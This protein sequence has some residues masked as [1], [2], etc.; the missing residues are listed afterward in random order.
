[1][2]KSLNFR[3]FDLLQVIIPDGGFSSSL[4]SSHF[5]ICSTL[6]SFELKSFSKSRHSFFVPL[7]DTVYSNLAFIYFSLFSNGFGMV[8][9]F[10]L[11]PFLPHS[12]ICSLPYFSNVFLPPSLP[13]SC[14]AGFFIIY[15]LLL[16]I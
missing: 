6:T 14:A 2:R 5:F 16:M 4:T 11:P 7:K 1:M 9:F 3:Y 13:N 12:F 10:G 8:V 15:S